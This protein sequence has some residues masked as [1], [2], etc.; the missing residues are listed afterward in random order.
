M[1]NTLEAYEDAG[2]RCALSRNQ[3]DEGIAHFHQTWMFKAV[4]DE[5]KADQPAARAAYNKGYREERKP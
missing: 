4:D 3:R 1:I 5:A 2:R